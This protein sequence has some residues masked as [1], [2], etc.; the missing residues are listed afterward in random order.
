M[1]SL[2]TLYYTVFHSRKPLIF[3]IF[4]GNHIILHK[5]NTY[6]FISSA[7]REKKKI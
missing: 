5:E 6:N 3:V 1:P 7:G 4:M 2:C